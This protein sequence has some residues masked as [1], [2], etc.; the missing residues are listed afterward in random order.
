[1]SPPSERW[2]ADRSSPV[3]EA[4]LFAQTRPTSP[5]FSVRRDNV[6]MVELTYNF[7]RAWTGGVLKRKR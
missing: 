6:F 7:S 3:R 5:L 1:M 4:R 2:F